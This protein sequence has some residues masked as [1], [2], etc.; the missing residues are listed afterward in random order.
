MP[1]GRLRCNKIPGIKLISLFL[2]VSGWIIVVA[3]MALL[4]SGGL[5][6]LFM[7]AGSAIEAVGLVFLFRAQR[8]AAGSRGNG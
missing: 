5:L 6:G 3:A 2:L 4:A 8:V 7:L 1:C